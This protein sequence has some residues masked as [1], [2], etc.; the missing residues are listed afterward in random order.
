MRFN[1]FYFTS[2]VNPV[3][4]KP[5]KKDDYPISGL[6]NSTLRLSDA[7][8]VTSLD[9]YEVIYNVPRLIEKI[10]GLPSYPKE[11]ENAPFWDVS[12]FY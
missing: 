6:T 3:G 4:F 12:F 7:Y 1:K 2:N 11:D 10:G 5:L 9:D 8:S